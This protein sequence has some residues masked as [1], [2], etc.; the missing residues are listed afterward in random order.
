[1]RYPQQRNSQKKNGLNTVSN[2]CEVSYN[3]SV[4]AVILVIVSIWHVIA[5][6]ERFVYGELEKSCII[7]RCSFFAPER[8]PNL[9]RC[10]NNKRRCLAVLLTCCGYAF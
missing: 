10:E 8:L 2:F 7:I 4:R 1:M 5:S 9:M 3:T 6:S